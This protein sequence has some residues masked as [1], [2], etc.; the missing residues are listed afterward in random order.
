MEV[1]LD[2]RAVI[3]GGLMG[4]G[5]AQVL[6]KQSS[7]VW[8]YDVSSEKLKL[9]LKRIEDS[10][11]LLERYNLIDSTSSREVLGR[12]SPTTNLEEALHNV[13]FVVE[14]APENLSLKQALFAK[15]EHFTSADT[16]IATNS[17]GLRV[18]DV[19]SKLRL[20]E[21]VVGSH[22][23]LPAQVVPLVEVSRGP[24]TSDKTMNETVALWKACGKEPIR[25]EHDLPGYI[26]NRLQAALVREATSLL[27]RGVATA[28]DI[29]RAVRTGFGIRYLVSGPLEQRD[30]GGLDLHVDLSTSL[31]PD[32]NISPG[33]HPFVVNM[34]DKGKLGLKSGE[35]FIDWKGQSPEEV[36]KSRTEDLIKIMGKIKQSD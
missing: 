31:W 5:I 12:I 8:L 11:Q 9:S 23:F 24:K 4:H 6:A 10:L 30:L 22:F 29:D 36:L 16:I 34:V 13:S 17:S 14:A 1:S 28:E 7:L 15:I 26:A 21:R 33:P 3:G 25:V 32:L 2:P 27:G 19:S 18:K 35:G 20:L